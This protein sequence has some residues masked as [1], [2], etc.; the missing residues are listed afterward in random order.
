LPFYVKFTVNVLLSFSLTQ[1]VFGEN[2]KTKD[3]DINQL[4]LIPA[5]VF[6]NQKNLSWNINQR[7]LR[8]KIPGVSIAIIED[9]KIILAKGSG[10]NFINGT[11]AISDRTIFQ[12]ASISKLVTAVAVLNLVEEK[13]LSLDENINTYLKSWKLVE[14]NYTK[15]N[16]VTLRQLLSHTSGVNNDG[17][18]GYKITDKIPSLLQILNG[19]YPSNAKAIKV[20]KTPGESV[21]Y[22]GGGYLILQKLIEDISGKTFKEYSRVSVFENADMSSS[23]FEQP[24]INKENL[25]V[26]CGHEFNGSKVVDCYNIYPELAAAGLWST[27]TDLAKFVI[28]LTEAMNGTNNNVLEKE[29]AIQMMTPIIGNMGLGPGLHGV[30]NN[31][32]FDHA[33]WNKGYRSYALMYPLLKKG[34]VVL[35][36]ADSGKALIDEIVRGVA[37]KYSWPDF[38]PKSYKIHSVN[39]P[40]LKA[41]SGDY[42]VNKYGF[43]LT[44]KAMKDFLM[45]STPRGSW[46][47]FYPVSGTE[48][49]ALE[50]GSRLI[51]NSDEAG[52]MNTINLWGMTAS[53]KQN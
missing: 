46:Y 13:N 40:T 47:S 51:F 27:A 50:D 8:Y 35:V 17:Y 31:I 21:R 15:K 53:L 19:T 34:V 26:A 14:N 18:S 45:L 42:L 33:G 28:N 38:K 49:I 36:N 52:Q 3:I 24:L 7:M 1:I 23:N 48:F 39:S 25:V 9:G 11:E 37:R 12:A 6:E 16:P 20:E 2:I 44:I 41:F 43:T 5:V 30:G 32:H 10:V 4:E 29:T 22:S